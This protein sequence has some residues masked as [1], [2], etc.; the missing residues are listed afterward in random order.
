MWEKQFS[1][2]F[3]GGD[4]L[5]GGKGAF[6]SIN[7]LTVVVF[8]VVALICFA[9]GNAS[10]GSAHAAWHK[11]QRARIPDND[12]LL[13]CA[14]EAVFRRLFRA[15]YFFLKKGKHNNTMENHGLELPDFTTR[16]KFFQNKIPQNIQWA[17]R[18]AFMPCCGRLGM[19]FHGDFQPA[20]YYK[21]RRSSLGY[22]SVSRLLP[23]HKLFLQKLC[24]TLHKGFVLHVLNPKRWTE[25]IC[26][27]V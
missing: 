9:K 23:W 1:L 12:G 17:T 21:P 26:G 7:W 6:Q 15:P 18:C 4:W 14:G 3:S 20:Q 27:S 11:A 10:A 5:H 25:D 16:S 19:V 2:R 8:V 13:S 22:P 24:F